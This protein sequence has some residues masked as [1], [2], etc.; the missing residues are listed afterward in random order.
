MPIIRHSPVS[1]PRIAL[2]AH[3]DT[4]NGVSMDAAP[5]PKPATR[6][7]I[8][9]MAREPLDPAW[10]AT[11]AQVTAPAPTRGHFLP[12]VSAMRE[13]CRLRRVGE[14]FSLPAG[15][16]ERNGGKKGGH[17]MRLATKQPAWSVETTVISTVSAI[18][19]ISPV[20]VLDGEL[21]VLV[22]QGRHLFAVVVIPW[23][24]KKPWSA[25]RPRSSVA[26]AH[27]NS[28]LELFVCQDSADGADTGKH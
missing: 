28:L 14:V 22:E 3:S 16:R 10:R 8:Y 27:P 13:V 6:R 15:A 19:T 25:T 18:F 7:P 9:M 12:Q 17:T 4:Y 1:P 11:P 2:G 26:R 24:T 21:A 5:T 20:T 23:T